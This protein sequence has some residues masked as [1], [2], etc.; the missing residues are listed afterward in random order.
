MKIDA[1]HQMSPAEE[2]LLAALRP[3]AGGAWSR[4]HANLSSQL[5]V[6]VEI[7]GERQT[8]PMSGVRNLAHSPDRDLRRRAFA[9]EIETWEQ[10]AL[11]LAASMNGIKGEVLT[12]SARRG[13]DSPLA[14]MLHANRIDQETLDAMLG[15]AEEFF[16]DFR[17]YLKAKARALGLSQLAWY[18]LF[19]PVGG[20]TDPGRWSFENGQE[21]IIQ[22]FGSYSDRLRSFAERAFAE[23]W[24]DA[25]PRPGK[26]D[27]AFCMWLQ[28]DESRILANYEPSYGAVSTL[29]HELGHA[30]HNLCEVGLTALQRGTPMTMAETASIF[31]ETIV[32]DA[33]L[34]GAS[35]DEQFTIL[36]A[37]L[38]DACQ[39]V[40]DI[41]S[42]FRF[43][44]AVFAQRDERDLSIDELK[45]LM[46]NA[47]AE[48]YGDG[49]DASTYHPYMWA[50]KGHYYSASESYYNFPY[51][52]GLLFGLGL[53]ARSTDD[54]DGF[55]AAY[56][57]LLAHTGRADAATLAA[58]FGI[59]LRQPAF[60]RASL[61]LIRADIDRFEK[62]VDARVGG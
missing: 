43:E 53:Y 60:W 50:V 30:Y 46:L 2:D 49:L 26:S 44:R 59:D 41:S 58:R 1:V 29:A 4:L 31:C 34:V 48:T 40:V 16:P 33:A 37:S 12:V 42:R 3:S 25:E 52:F 47:Q 38:Q 7:D 28:G 13:W 39:V 22:H 14:A 35:E 32:K 55:R 51:M 21:F 62:L 57:D 6:T 19:A 8:L 10:A 45:A 11:S 9:A 18:D 27:G 15:A 36:E 56:D 23:R 17:R 20:N 54:P 61:E 5:E 24:I